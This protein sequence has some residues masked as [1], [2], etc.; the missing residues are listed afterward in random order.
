MVELY[1]VDI[2]GDNRT[3]LHATFSENGNPITNMNFFEGQY[4]SNNDLVI[5]IRL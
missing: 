5:L 1:R 3:F 4:D 2:W